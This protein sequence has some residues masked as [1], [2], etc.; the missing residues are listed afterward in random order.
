MEE[1]VQRKAALHRNRQEEQAIQ[2]ALHLPLQVYRS[3]NVIQI[4]GVHLIAPGNHFQS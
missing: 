2:E 4:H 1:A 3:L